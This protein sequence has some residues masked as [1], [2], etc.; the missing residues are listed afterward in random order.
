ML[1]LT[2]ARN[3]RQAVTKKGNTNG[4]ILPPV[5]YQPHPH[6]VPFNIAPINIRSLRHKTHEK[7]YLLERHSLS[8]LAITETWLDEND[9]EGVINIDGYTLF[10]RDRHHQRG[11]EVRIY[12]R[13][14]LRVHL[15]ERY[16]R[17]PMVEI[18]WINISN[19]S[20]EQAPTK[21]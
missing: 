1:F 5:A 19:Q 9:N 20:Q 7:E 14:D 13:E 12:V 2:Q 6:L 21:Q 17:N 11:G 18:I 8:V 15:E 4:L 3:K 10:R 16:S